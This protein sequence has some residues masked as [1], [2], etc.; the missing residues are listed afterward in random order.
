VDEGK[1]VQRLGEKYRL[2]VEPL[3]AAA[4][5][6]MRRLQELD[7]RPQWRSSKGK[8][9]P[10]VSDNGNPII[11]VSLPAHHD[12]A[13]LAATLDQIPGVIGH[14][15]FINYAHEILIARTDASAQRVER[16]AISRKD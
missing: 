5:F 15:L 12:P 14:G 16:R 4:S 8:L 11:D 3:P 6:V 2:P 1:L 9:G 7:L 10:V 13:K